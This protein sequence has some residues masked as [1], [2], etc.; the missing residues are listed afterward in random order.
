VITARFL[1]ATAA[2]AL[3]LSLASAT[4]RAEPYLAVQ[5]GYKCVA[6]HVN[7]TGGGMRNAFG[8]VF[9]QNVLPANRIDV[10]DDSWTG[11]INRYVMIGGDVRADWTSTAIPNQPQT[12]EFNV[13]DARV[14]L[15]LEAI[16]GRLSMYVDERVAPG[17]ATNLETYVRYWTADQHWFAQAGRMYLPFGLR[18]QDNSAFT[19]EVPGINMTTPDTGVEVGWESANWTAQLALSNGS[20][21]GPETNNG[22]QVTGQVVY[23]DPRWRAGLASSYNQSDAGDRAVYGLFGGL[24]TG[25]VAW[26]GEADLVVDHG[27]PEG[28]RNLV[29]A[30]LEADWAVM[31]GHN[32]KLTGEWFDPDRKVANDQQTRWSA[33]YEYSPI[34]FLQLRGGARFYNGIPQNDLQNRTFYF[35][36]LHGFF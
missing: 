24:R 9:A 2:I 18:L 26:L 23:V 10:G 34:Q 4:A 21:G 36:E 17:S 22:K 19:R 8:N 12:N 35:V 32:L 16:P 11:A 7:P 5:Q 3:S 31:R 30:L 29:T 27:F 1:G 15:N 25:P 6:C 13:S 28:T 14:Y 20:A 33:V